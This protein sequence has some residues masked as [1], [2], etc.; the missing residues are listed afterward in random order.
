MTSIRSHVAAFLAALVVPALGLAQLPSADAAKANA[1]VKAATGQKEA[2]AA[3]KSSTTTEQVKTKAKETG[4]SGVKTGTDKGVE[5]AKAVVGQDKAT[6]AGG[7]VQEK[8]NVGVD[9]GV[10]KAAEKLMK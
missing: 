1:E 5:K 9:K 2:D 4:K 6:A 7:V 3:K 8:G 10:D